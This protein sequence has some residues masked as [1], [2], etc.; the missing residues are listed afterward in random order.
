MSQLSAQSILELCD[1]SNSCCLHA[2]YEYEGRPI[3][4]ISPF[5]EAR[6]V[7]RGRSAGLSAA[8]YDVRIAHDLTLGVNP[9]FVIARVLMEAPRGSS[10]SVLLAEVRDALCEAQRHSCFALAHTLEDFA[11]PDNVAGYVCD[12]ST[13]AR[14]HVSAFNTLFDPGFRGNATIE[15]VNHSD[16]EV[17]LHQGDPICQLVFHW[18]DRETDR[19]YRGKFQNQPKSPIGARYEYPDGSFSP[20]D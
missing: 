17:I 2:R 5:S 16:R 8:S 9:A 19:P 20:I 7:I 15:L 14:L 11:M 1:P 18:L 6:L 10:A 13:Y 4:M 12:K 3:P